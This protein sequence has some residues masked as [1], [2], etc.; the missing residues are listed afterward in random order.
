MRS[1]HR[2][3]C[4][5]NFSHFCRRSLCSCKLINAQVLV[6]RVGF[7]TSLDPPNASR[8]ITAFQVYTFS[9]CV[10]YTI[11]PPDFQPPA[12]KIFLL[13]RQSPSNKQKIHRGSSPLFF[14]RF[15]LTP[16]AENKIHSNLIKSFAHPQTSATKNPPHFAK[17]GRK[18]TAPLRGN[19]FSTVKKFSHHGEKIQSQWP[20]DWPPRTPKFCRATPIT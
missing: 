11:F 2:V 12:T 13:P 7:H 20:H 4:F 16:F 19:F 5:R 9:R 18:S 6:L 8:T 10:Y 1:L 3:V 15:V 14:F 17:C